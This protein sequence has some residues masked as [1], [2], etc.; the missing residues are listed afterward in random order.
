VSN[1][2]FAGDWVGP[3]GYLVDASL[4]SARETARQ[5]L[6]SGAEARQQ[7]LRAA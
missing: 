4:G 3:R 6:L 5:I 2:Y 1:V 7:A